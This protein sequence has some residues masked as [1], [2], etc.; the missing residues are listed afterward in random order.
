MYYVYFNDLDEG[1]LTYGS[2]R[3]CLHLGTCPNVGIELNY[4]PLAASH[5][6]EFAH[7]GLER[8]P[9]HP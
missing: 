6:P 7:F 5:N 1:I 8:S 2:I 9:L 3:R 4:L